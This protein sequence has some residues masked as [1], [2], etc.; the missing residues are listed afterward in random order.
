M[1][2]LKPEKIPR[3]HTILTGS[4]FDFAKFITSWISDTA[5]LIIFSI[6]DAAK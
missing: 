3:F 6:Q 5:N 4:I 1:S 2:L